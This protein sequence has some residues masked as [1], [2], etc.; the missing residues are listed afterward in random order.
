MRMPPNFGARIRPR[1][2]ALPGA[3]GRAGSPFPFAHELLTAREAS[4]YLRIPLGTLQFWRQPRCRR[5]PR[6]RFIRAHSHRIL[7]RAADLEKFLAA[8]TVDPGDRR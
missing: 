5:G 1:Q 8:R 3:P 7:Y 2:V 4:E 6:L